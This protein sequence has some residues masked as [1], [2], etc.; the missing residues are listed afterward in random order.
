MWGRGEGEGGE[1]ELERRGITTEGAKTGL[2]RGREEAR[3]NEGEEGRR[4]DGLGGGRK[5]EEMRERKGGGARRKRGR[6]REGSLR[7]RESA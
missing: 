5:K 7:G 2:P 6:A 3:G 1:I 4:Q